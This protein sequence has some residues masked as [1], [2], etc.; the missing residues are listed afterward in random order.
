MLLDEYE[1]FDIGRY[2]SNLDVAE[3]LSQLVKHIRK[4][5]AFCEDIKKK[6]AR[7]TDLMDLTNIINEKLY[8]WDGEFSCSLAEPDRLSRL[9]RYIHPNLIFDVRMASCDLPAYRIVRAKYDMCS[10]YNIILEI[11][12]EST[13]YQAQMDRF[14][15]LYDYTREVQFINLA[16]FRSSLIDEV[17]QQHL[18]D[19]L[20]T[21]GSH[22][23]SSAWDEDQEVCQRVARDFDLGVFAHACELI[24]LVSGGE[25]PRIANLLQNDQRFLNFF[26]EYYPQPA[27]Y[28]FLSKLKDTPGNHL[29]E[30]QAKGPEVYVELAKAFSDFTK[31][32]VRWGNPRKLLCL[33]DIVRANVARLNLVH[34]I[35]KSNNVYIE[36]CKELQRGSEVAI[37]KLHGA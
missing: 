35:L 3:E 6:G 15:P 20:F 19:F 24:Y 5:D 10:G 16:P 17:D 9:L 13:C 21:V 12:F 30:V 27:I 1:M 2:N 29:A 11:Y 14:V 7:K 37:A 26:L 31:E 18:D 28:T 34:D 8:F 25:L 23:L 33:G 32:E 4:M 22:I 36:A